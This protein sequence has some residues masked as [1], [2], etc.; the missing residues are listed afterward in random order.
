M[1]LFRGEYSW[2]LHSDDLLDTELPLLKYRAKGGT[3]AM[4]KK[5]LDPFVTICTRGLSASFLPL[6]FAVPGLVTSIH[7]T[8]YLP[9]AGKHTEFVEELSKLDDCIE[10]LI[11]E[12][13]D[14]VLF[15]R[16]D[17]NV[18]KK[19][20]TRTAL[21]RKLCID[22]NL[23]ETDVGHPTYHHFTGN[24]FSDSQLD[25]LLRTKT[26]S[27]VIEEI[28]CKLDN[29]L[30]LSH[31]DALLSRFSLRSSA[32]SPPDMDNPL[33]PR[34]E[35]NR[36]KVHWSN[37]GIV[38]YKTSVEEN[39]ARIR[40]NWLDSSSPAS[41]SVLLQATNSFLD[42]CARR[43]NGFTKLSKEFRS[44]SAKKPAYLVHSERKLM[45]SHKTLR[46]MSRLSPDFK[47]LAEQHQEAKRQHQRL[48]R[49][50]KMEECCFRDKTLNSLLSNDASPAY[51]AIKHLKNP[52]ASK[53]AKITVGKMTYL[54]D[55]V[56]DGMFESIR[57]LKMD[58][59]V[60]D[61]EDTFPDFDEDYRNI[62]DICKS[63]KKI[64]KLSKENSLKILM[65]MRKT[66]SDFYSITALHYLNAGTAGHDHFHFLL[67]TIIDNVN[68]GGLSELNTI[69]ACVLYKGHLKDKTSSRSYRTISTC[70]LVAKA[71]DMY[72]RD[73][74]LPDWN[75]AQS[76]TQYQGEGSSHELAALLLTEVIQHS[77][78]SLK[79]PVF[80][81]FLDAKSA[82]DRVL[83]EILI[84]NLFVAGTDGHRLL[85]LDQRLKNRK[86]FCEYDK[87]LMGPIQDNKGLEQGGVKS[88]DEYKIYNN[89]QSKTAQKSGLGV[90]IKDITISSISLADDTVLVANDIISLK[91]LLYLTTQYCKKYSVELVPDKTKLI[92]FSNKACVPLTKYGIL[93]S[94]ISLH[95]KPV[96]FSEEA[97]HLGI[98]RTSQPG[99]MANV[100]D[101]L[102]AHNKKLF[103]ILPAGLA[104]GHHA[105]PAACLL[106]EQRYALPVLLSGLAGLLLSKAEVDTV[107]ACYKNTLQRLMK[108]HERSSDCV[109]YF[110]AGSLPGSA[111]LHLRQLS[112]FSM[113][114]HLRDDPL[115]SMAVRTI[116]EAKP[117][118]RSWFQDI[119]DLCIQYNLPHPLTLLQSP[120]PKLLFKN[121]CQ[122]RVKE[123]W[124]SKLSQEATLPS[125]EFLQPEFLSLTKPHP[126]WRSL[127]GNPYQ[128]KAAKIQALFLSGRYRTQRLSR[129]WSQN[130][131]GVCLMDTCKHEKIVEDLNH[132]IIRCSGLNETRR[133]LISFTSNYICDK[134]VLQPLVTAY[135]YAAD[136]ENQVMQF[137]LDCSVLP[138]VITAYQKY[139]PVIH[140]QLFRVTR[141]WCRALHRD[142]LKALGLYSNQ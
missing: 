11:D 15:I 74:S 97:E 19:D 135:L 12:H 87:Q 129:F 44:K 121:L 73:L 39:L 140:E 46:N 9:T 78:Y 33:A 2:S 113:V 94:G 117:A 86:T 96:P 56:P 43:T 122:K 107:S 14:A 128:A 75:S 5:Q 57:S 136:N 10:S 45:K 25:V 77:L 118:A 23:V 65:R 101:R 40:S 127:D 34:I 119:R 36:V 82:F 42:L 142:R 55:T 134:P 95:G 47:R 99:N 59:I 123:Y 102:S 6:V 24:G 68:L 137:I 79:L 103:S 20:K 124:H 38:N 26:E 54:G 1:S 61:A 29:P 67:N 110:L 125:L 80:A 108:L 51:K 4:W 92:A 84:R 62:L 16:G 91:H 31:H 105:N 72:V 81:I 3:M 138:M 18:N 66:V 141:T 13:P 133:R 64:P 112:L 114:C 71:L 111:L 30:I 130:K 132:I 83:K 53:L 27:E 32:P 106:A 115:N 98:L 93:T 76:S 8:I 49:L 104:L 52:R 28:Y 37:E 100:L 131:D 90:T 58:P 63:G 21:F 50:Q 89:E 70:P 48:L 35:N 85:Y 41:V 120:L 139:G 109:V 7:I 60:R 88:S 69:F 22:W 17:S 126:I 116:I